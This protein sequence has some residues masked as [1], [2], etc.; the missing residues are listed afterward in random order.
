MINARLVLSVALIVVLVVSPDVISSSYAQTPEILT[1][2]QSPF[3]HGFNDVKF[4]DAYFGPAGQKIEVEPGDKNIP[5]TVVLSNVGT[6]DITGIQGTLSLPTGFS[7]AVTGNGLIQA[8][9]TQ[10]AT[11][12]QS[13]TLTFFINVDKSINIHDY[14]G[15]IK[16]S[17]SRVRENGERTAYLDFNFKVTGKGV[18]NL[19]AQNPF[20]NPASNNDITIQISDAGTA[21]LN[22]VDVVIQRDQST[23]TT[24]TTN[25]LQGI[26]LDQ[27]HWKVGTVHPD[28]SNT[29]AIHAFIPQNVAGQTIHAPFTV[30]YFDGQGNQVTTTR[31]VDFIV[32]PTSTVSIIKLSSPPYIMTGIMQ[33][34][35]LGIENLSPSQISDIS[36]SITPNSSNLKILQDN[37]WFVQDIGPLEKT[38]LV[39]PVFADSSIEGQ[40]VDY[41]VDIQYTKDGATVIEKQNFATYLRGV[42]DISVH[43]IG[44]TQIAGKQMIIGN[45]LNQGNVK[46]VFGQ[47]TVLPVDNS[48]IKKST[49]YIGDIDIDAPVPF[50]IPINSDS[51]PTGDQK[52]Q[53][54]LTWKDTLLQQHTLTEVDTVSFGTPAVQSSSNPSFNQLQVVIL[55]AIAAGI[56]GIVFKAR[57]K[58]VVLE[59]KVEQSS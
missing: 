11:A 58:K 12:G 10:T 17:Y 14:S 40:A 35:T 43:D 41:E 18:V 32:G 9:N 16:V 6:E 59:K 47:V 52:I 55:V 27:N 29:F 31:T 36:I 4:L 37:K 24:G 2:S 49:Q 34:L 44:V 26:V 7:G 22:D 39:I 51:P 38:D 50:N 33:N 56:G 28:S 53:V 21:P 57:K 3:E 30:T 15:T 23:S 5:F 54:T 45:V 1:P 8:D 46:A 13:F 48:V 20:L 19:K 42:I 25:S